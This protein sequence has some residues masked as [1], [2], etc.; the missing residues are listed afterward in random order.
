MSL[1][2]KSPISN[3]TIGNAH[4]LPILR[5]IMTNSQQPTANSQQPTA[6]SQQPTAN[7]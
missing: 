3:R 7:N 6:N 2:L 5:I 4:A 1:N